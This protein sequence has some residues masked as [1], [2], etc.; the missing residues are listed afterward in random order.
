MTFWEIVRNVVAQRNTLHYF[1]PSSTRNI[2]CWPGRVASVS[3]TEICV[4]WI[5]T[6]WHLKK[7]LEGVRVTGN[8]N[9][10]CCIP[11][12]LSPLG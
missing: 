4:A 8:C 7:R 10:L 3:R 12:K 9:G 1:A 2:F 6:K 5:N 11:L